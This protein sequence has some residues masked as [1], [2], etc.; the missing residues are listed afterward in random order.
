LIGSGEKFLNIYQLKIKDLENLK[1][2]Y[3]YA[4]LKGA[5]KRGT[6]GKTLELSTFLTD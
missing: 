1:G 5:L 6:L 4:Q 2:Q 3:E